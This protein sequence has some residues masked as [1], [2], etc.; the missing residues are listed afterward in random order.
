MRSFV[1]LVFASFIFYLL[2]TAGSG[3]IFLWSMPELMVG[4]VFSLAVG[5]L[6]RKFVSWK[7][8]NRALNPLRWVAF[9]LY[10]VGPFL[11]H[12]TKANLDVAYRVI[13]GKIN[14]GIVKI[15]PDLKTG[16][17]TT[18]LANSITLT[19]GTLT[20]DV[21]DKNE[22]LVHWINVTDK[23]PKPEQVYGSMGKW[24]KWVME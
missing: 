17:A 11:F 16:L 12:M 8:S 19:P 22:L 2:L 5:V 23:K 1:L 3:D 20:V 15:K 7:F 6:S 24:I 13:T 18:V 21:T 4:F 9:A 10:L 14:P